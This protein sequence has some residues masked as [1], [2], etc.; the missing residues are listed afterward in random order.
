MLVW[1]HP[2]VFAYYYYHVVFVNLV[3]YF[4]GPQGD[5]DILVFSITNKYTYLLL[6]SKL[7]MQTLKI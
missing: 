4:N 2:I 5:I 6:I 1:T 3:H 7:L